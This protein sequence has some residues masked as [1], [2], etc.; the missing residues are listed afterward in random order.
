VQYVVVQPRQ[1]STAAVVS[2]V[3]GILSL[4]G[5]WCCLGFPGFVALGVGWL[6][7]RETKD[8]EIAG[9]GMAVAGIILGGLT[10]IPW[11]ILG[12][13]AGIGG[14]GNAITGGP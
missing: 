4:L 2:L 9:N 6:G 14:I 1:T 3:A 12:L 11:L 5:G 7:Y 10:G 13:F 8:G